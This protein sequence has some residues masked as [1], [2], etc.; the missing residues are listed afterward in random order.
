MFLLTQHVFSS[1]LTLVAHLTYQVAGQCIELGK[2]EMYTRYSDT[3]TFPIDSASPGMPQMAK[4]N[5]IF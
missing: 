4:N 2:T 5:F 1:T 3:S